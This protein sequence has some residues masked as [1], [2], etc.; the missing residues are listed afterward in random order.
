MILNFCSPFWNLKFLPFFTIKYSQVPSIKTLFKYAST[1]PH[2]NELL[3]HQLDKPDTSLPLEL[4]V[5]TAPTVRKSCTSKLFHHHQLSARK[6][7]KS[8][9]HTEAIFARAAAKEKLLIHFQILPPPPP[10]SPH[11]HSYIFSI[12][13]NWNTISQ[14]WKPGRTGPGISSVGK[15]GGG[16]WQ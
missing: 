15:W 4:R 11:V 8:L 7:P 12:L 5:K 10:L 9:K 13:W 3:H 1:F 14:K 16:S 2:M 6:M